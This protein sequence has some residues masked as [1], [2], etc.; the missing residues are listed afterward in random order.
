MQQFEVDSDV[1]DA[2][3][4][5]CNQILPSLAFLSQSGV[6]SD[7]ETLEQLR[8]KWCAFLEKELTGKTKMFCLWKCVCGWFDVCVCM[9]VCVDG[10]VCVCERDM[11]RNRLKERERE[12]ERERESDRANERQRERNSNE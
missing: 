12:R 1:S 11:Q 6:E 4:L 9:H 2:L 10:C 8:G 5:M 7:T 3:T